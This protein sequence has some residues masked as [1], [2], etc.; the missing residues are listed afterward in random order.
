MAHTAD[1]SSQSASKSRLPS[2]A[3]DSSGRRE[4]VELPESDLS[5]DLRRITGATIEALKAA[6]ISCGSFQCFK[7]DPKPKLWR[8]N[9][10]SLANT[11]AR[12]SWDERLD[13]LL[14]L[15]SQQLDHEPR[16]GQSF[17][18]HFFFVAR[19]YCSCVL[20]EAWYLASLYGDCPELEE[21]WDLSTSEQALEFLSQDPWGK[22][23]EKWDGNKGFTLIGKRIACGFGANSGIEQHPTKIEILVRREAAKALESLPP[24]TPESELAVGPQSLQFNEK[25]SEPPRRKKTAPGEARPK[26]IAVLTHHHEYE[27]GGVLNYDAIGN[28]TLAQ[29]AEVSTGAA[30]NFFKQEFGGHGEYR[31]S[32]M[33]CDP[34]RKKLM[35]LNGEL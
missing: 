6:D 31:I 27:D 9:L 11:M 4:A 34:L 20:H 19:H 1:S 23:I 12:C 16:I 13:N 17:E 29:S 7:N 10:F 3:P 15:A 22:L 5:E 14:I 26:I 33:Q 8:D 25:H 30:S 24:V 35:Q 21:F 18:T 28:N 2:I 32:C